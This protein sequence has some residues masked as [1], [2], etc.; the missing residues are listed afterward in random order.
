MKQASVILVLL[1]FLSSLGAFVAG[2]IFVASGIGRHLFAFLILFVVPLHCL[3]VLLF[4]GS[5]IALIRKKAG[6]GK[7]A[8]ISLSATAF[9]FVL[10]PKYFFSEGFRGFACSDQ[11][12]SELTQEALE[13]LLESILTSPR[14]EMYRRADGTAKGILG[15]EEY[16]ELNSYVLSI[17]AP[18]HVIFRNTGASRFLMLEWGS[19]IVGRYGIVYDTGNDA[20]SSYRRVHECS[21]NIYVVSR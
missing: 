10:S 21:R 15:E 7:I 14:Y 12:T 16:A 20:T 13:D 2:R 9:L 19:A 18:Q 17:Y 3:S 6:Y 4:I 1:C 8:L 11:V 5:S